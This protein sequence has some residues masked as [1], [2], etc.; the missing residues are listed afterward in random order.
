MNTTLI[1][2]CLLTITL[3]TFFSCD[4]DPKFETPDVSHIEVDAELIRFDQQLMHI[5][6][7]DATSVGKG[8]QSLYDQYP[9]FAK[10]YF[11]QITGLY[12]EDQSAFYENVYLFLTDSRIQKL[13]GMI[14]DQFDEM[15]EVH[16]ELQ[17]ACKFLKY[18]FPVEKAPDFYTLFS[19]F[20]FQS[21]IFTANE[22]DA[23]GIGL[24]MFLGDD[25]DYKNVDPTNPAFS[26][27]LS[28]TYTKEHIVKK[29]MDILIED[30]IGQAPGKRFLDQIIHKGKKLY[31]LQHILPA[32]PDTILFEYTA[33]QWE[34]LNDNELEM[35]SF[36]LEKELLY[37]TNHLRINKYIN[38]SPSSPGMP[39]EAPGRTGT[40]IGY[41]I[42]KNFM[43]RNPEMT[44]TE[45]VAFRDAQKL[46]EIAKYKPKRR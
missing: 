3:I 30:L 42:V 44:L 22:K 18:Y 27:Y 29:S 35:W 6:T 39:V 31:V 45:L 36:F 15:N 40:F 33:E 16:Y 43:A 26:E 21:F 23:I 11:N 32:A 10:L 34:W 8:I 24:D 12:K 46:M 38:N 28:R 5:D 7:S 1:Y 25:F 20:A 2:T 17:Q 9:D 4:N 14:D 19:E 37:E 41:Q 13:M